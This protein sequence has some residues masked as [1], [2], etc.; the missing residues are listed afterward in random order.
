MQ[1]CSKQYSHSVSY[2]MFFIFERQV[3]VITHCIHFKIKLSDTLNLDVIT[4]VVKDE[5]LL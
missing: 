4:Q 5:R 1:T 3:C 2:E